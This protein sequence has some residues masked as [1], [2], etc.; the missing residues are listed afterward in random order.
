MVEFSAVNDESEDL[1]E[2]T[3]G[4]LRAL[5]AFVGGGFRRVT[6]AAE[7]LSFDGVIG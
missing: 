6:K 3:C 2:S 7:R 5:A 1:S 4:R